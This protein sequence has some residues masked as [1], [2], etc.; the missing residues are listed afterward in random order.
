MLR[1]LTTLLLL[2]LAIAGSALANP[3]G[4]VRVIDGDTFLVG[5]TRVRLH[6]IDAPEA[7]QTC[8]T[9]QGVRW[10]CGDWASDEARKRFEGGYATCR[11]IDTVRYGRTVARCHVD[12]VEVGQSLVQDGVAFAYRKYARRYVAA[13]DRARARAA[14]LW[15]MQVQSPAQYRKTR[16]ASRAATSDKSCAIKGNISSRGEKIY[17]VPGQRYHARTR[18]SPGKGERWFCSEAEARR[19]GWRKSKI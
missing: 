3:S 4:V 10:A 12:G 2:P 7:A 5:D 8:R 17:H 19:A 16:A 15:A 14:G 1:L 11:A 6:G 9:E 13:E 18:I